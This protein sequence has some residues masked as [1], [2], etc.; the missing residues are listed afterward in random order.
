[1]T[2][3]RRIFGQKISLLDVRKKHNIRMD[4]K[5]A[6]PSLME[7]LKLDDPDWLEL[8][9]FLPL[10][11]TKGRQPNYLP[12][13]S[14][15]PEEEMAMVIN[16]LSVKPYFIN[17][18]TCRLVRFEDFETLN[19]E[20]KLKRGDVVLTMD[21]G[22]SIGKSAIFDIDDSCTVDSHISIL[23]PSGITSL[24]L[25]YLLNSKIGQQQFKL[26]E[27]GSSGQTSVNEDDIRRFK[28]PLGDI[29][30]SES[31]VV[32]LHKRASEIEEEI[33]KLNDERKALSRQLLQ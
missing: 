2:T 14:D 24:L 13:N 6:D 8:G 30:M 23:R 27:S 29:E 28:F 10:P 16:T 25:I 31:K 5:Q 18:D 19:F 9:E 32:E 12:D 15:L 20:R 1:M 3:E 11:L 17:Y 22:T 21:G 7:D 26:A 33:A 4:A